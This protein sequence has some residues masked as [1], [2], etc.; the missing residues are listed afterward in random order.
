MS[1]S[2]N[3][4]TDA[5][6]PGKGR[7]AI[8]VIIA[9]ILSVWS[10]PK[11]HSLHYELKEGTPWIYEELIAPYSF[12]IEKSEEALK[13]ETDSLRA[14]FTP[15]FTRDSLATEK[16]LAAFSSA[17]EDSL[18]T[19][20][21]VHTFKLLAD[22]IESIYT[23]GIV[24][25]ENEGRLAS[26]YIRTVSGTESRLVS[27]ASVY[28]QKSAYQALM[29]VTIPASDRYQI[30][31]LKMEDFLVP[32]L[33]YDAEKSDSDLKDQEEQISRYSGAVM[34]GQ[35]IIDHGEI[36][37]PE[38]YMIIKSYMDFANRRTDTTGFKAMT[39]GGHLLFVSI[40]FIML[41]LYLR[42]Y[43]R[44]IVNDRRKR[45]FLIGAI[46]VFTVLTNIYIQFSSWS[47]FLLPCT[48][49]AL[50][51]RIFLDSRTAFV[52][53][54]VYVLTCSMVT[55]MP[56]EFMLLQ[57]IAGLAAIYSV[58]ELSQ[59]SQIFT[60]AA[61]I[62]LTYCLVWLTVQMIQIEDIRNVQ[63]DVFIF[64]AINSFILLLTYPLVF[65]IE[66]V[67]GFTSNVTLIELSNINHPL[68]REL[69]ENAPGTFQHSMQVSTLAAE[70]A[71][72]IGAS[73]Q[74]VR[75]AA[76]YHDIGKLSNPP[77]F[78]ENQSGVNPHD[79][80]GLID[81]A[82]IIT[83]HVTEGLKIAEKHK[84]P[85]AITDFIRTHHGTG[86]A[87]YFY[88]KYCNEHPGE[89]C[90]EA[91][92]RYAGTNPFTKETAILMMAD[93]V[94]ASSRSL[95]EFTDESIGTLVDRIIDSQVEDGFFK[96]CPITFL[97]I[98]EVK[99][100]FKEKLHNMYHTRI[101]YPELGK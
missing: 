15:Y 75:T 18:Y 45:L 52:G 34:A 10:M 5:A 11:T 95:K 31:Q 77:F 83:S 26:G 48:M 13:N 64:F 84:L 67:F 85:R 71:N 91:P 14:A 24:G 32:T 44:D 58:H 59:R 30:M 6:T 56:F 27:T 81:S 40:V 8:L 55:P 72:R 94:E 89:E 28:T 62:L 3:R 46:T 41:V 96:A 92:F 69:S 70:A 87:K 80:L 17:Y 90:D 99:E 101:S 37:N 49:L 93:A 54:L 76:L 61:A 51:L 43:R 66:K 88:I 35:K 22:Q 98:I 82:R 74:L 78:T 29:S 57:T 60:S 19:I 86:T 65:A 23:A 7:L 4:K 12:S 16:A 9:V 63:W 50:M 53:Y 21:S 97:E 38:T 79:K 47:I 36:V 68:L 42:Q 25:Q 39:W 100:V 1:R 20:V 2:E 73:A 33:L